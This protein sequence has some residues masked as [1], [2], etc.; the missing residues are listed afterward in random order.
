MVMQ[1]KPSE[2][3]LRT[4]QTERVRLDDR[5]PMPP[6]AFA[7]PM[8][9][10]ERSPSDLGIVIDLPPADGSPM[11]DSV[12]DSSVMKGSAVHDSPVDGSA[13]PALPAA[14]GDETASTAVSL[15]SAAMPAHPKASLRQTPAAARPAT[16]SS[17]P[18]LPLW[19]HT[20]Q[21]KTLYLTF[22]DG[23][24]DGTA[25]L[26]RLLKE[27]G[28]RATLFCIGRRVK[29]H[30][31]LLH[32]AQM[33][34]EILVANHTYS[35]AN[36]HYRRFYSGSARSVVAD[37]DRAQRLIGGAQYLR[38]AGRNVWR[39]PR[40]SRNDW[41]IS[42]AQR[43]REI[44]KYDALANRGYFIFG[45]DIEWRFSHTT[46]KPLF[47]GVEMAR[48]VEALYRSGK[49]ARKNRMVLLAHDFMWRTAASLRQL[50]IFIE[51]MKEQGWRFETVDSYCQTTPEAYAR[52]R[53]KTAPL[54]H[55]A[56]RV[57]QQT[58]VLSKPFVPTP[59]AATTTQS[60]QPSRTELVARLNEAIRHQQFIQMRRLIARGAR[61]NDRDAQGDLPLNVAIRTNNAV[62]VRML[63]ERGA[64][65]FRVDGDG[66]S[67][68]GVAHQYHNMII[69]RYLQREIEKQK[70][71]RLHKPVF[72]AL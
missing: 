20:P 33:M 6:E 59:P 30:P 44:P 36:E 37:I 12:A 9:P 39:L 31:E 15:P 51:I 34:P 24:L 67:P 14:A 42:K 27:Q 29:Q 18:A 66:M 54:T 56:Q 38:L 13:D 46:Q 21:S 28:I 70:K 22:D 49:T 19:H 69:I 40:L 1:K 68:L 25:N 65:L 61:I 52:L 64:N 53:A 32:K 62:L 10:A 71:N 17:K 47:G 4:P 16:S 35:H 2:Q 60:S 57:A 45:W 8:E 72:A 11:D 26:L 63:V 58:K 5:K 43:H 41:A 23:P 55:T 3:L 7:E 50:R 48:R